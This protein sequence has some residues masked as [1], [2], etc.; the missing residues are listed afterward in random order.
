MP[1]ALVIILIQI[2]GLFVSIIDRIYQSLSQIRI[3]L[4]YFIL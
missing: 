3:K 4:F 2:T 1:M